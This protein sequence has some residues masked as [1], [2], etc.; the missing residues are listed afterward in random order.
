MI[1][2]T[3]IIIAI[4]RAEPDA[5]EIREVLA[6]PQVRR[7]SAVSYVEAGVVVDSNRN[8]VLS[9]RFDD[10]LRDVQMTIEP[11]TVNQAR[12]AREAYRDFGKGRHRAG[13]NFGDCFAYALA[14]EKGE[15]LLF[16][17]DDFRQTDIEP[18]EA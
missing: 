8:P 16:K 13:L 2:D 12:L 10:L 7:M 17:G 14:K 6:R 4:L 15:T 11:V 9:R 1:V 18:A 5:A 3:S